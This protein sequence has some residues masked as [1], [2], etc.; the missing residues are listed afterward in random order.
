MRNLFTSQS[1]VGMTYY[2]ISMTTKDARNSHEVFTK[3]CNLLIIGRGLKK[4]VTQLFNK[5]SYV[6]QIKNRGFQRFGIEEGF[7]FTMLE[8]V[9]IIQF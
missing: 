4:R 2:V 1:L 9:C 8:Q 6:Y 3:G 7:F 5:N